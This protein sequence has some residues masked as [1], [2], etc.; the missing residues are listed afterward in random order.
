MTPFYAALI[1]FN[2]DA[3]GAGTVEVTPQPTMTECR[4]AVRTMMS[5]CV[6]GKLAMVAQ[7]GAL[8]DTCERVV[9]TDTRLVYHCGAL[10]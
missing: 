3:S 5:V 10:K 9:S 2:L 1:V 8:E 7:I 6:E 4:A